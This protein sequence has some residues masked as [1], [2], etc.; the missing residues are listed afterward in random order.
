MFGEFC[1]LLP[2]LSYTHIGEAV[3]RHGPEFC[4]VADMADIYIIFLVGWGQFLETYI[5]AFDVG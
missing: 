1:K 2:L 4:N 5:R 3:S